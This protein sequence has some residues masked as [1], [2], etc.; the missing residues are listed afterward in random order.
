MGPLAE[1]LRSRRLERALKLAR[2]DSALGAAE[3][4]PLGARPRA[5]PTSLPPLCVPLGSGLGG[6]G[7]PGLSYQ[8]P[9]RRARRGLRQDQPRMRGGVDHPPFLGPGPV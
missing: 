1:R 3:G 8:N 7:P 4:W 5:N 6:L 9:Q 2:Q